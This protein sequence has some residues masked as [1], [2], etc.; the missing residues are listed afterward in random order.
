MLES[1]GDALV[2]CVPNY[3]EGR[4]SA[5]VHA[6]LASMHLPGVTLLDYTL[7]SSQNRSVITIAGPPSAVCEAVVRSAGVAAERID[8]TRSLSAAGTSSP[9]GKAHLYPRMGAAD[10][11][12][13]VPLRNITLVQCAVLAREAAHLLWERHRLPSYL[14]AAA[15][16]RPDRVQLADFRHGQFEGLREAVLRD[17]GRRPDVGGPGLHPTAGAAAVGARQVLVEYKLFLETGD[18][19]A[20]RAVAKAVRG[21]EGDPAGVR[22]IALL[23]EGVAQ[24]AISIPDY[25]QTPLRFVHAA[26][27]A[28]AAKQKVQIARCE[29]VGLIPEAA[30]D[31]SPWDHGEDSGVVRTLEHRLAHPLPWPAAL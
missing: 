28:A 1:R 29:M 12:P 18:L 22:A 25:A 27:L 19:G 3:A 23:V 31:S 4:D 9:P 6:I 13:F 16:S 5:V 10:V 2:E 21:P 14:Y 17:A 24:V 30:G 26:A 7:D 20:A 11:I 8:L 15:A